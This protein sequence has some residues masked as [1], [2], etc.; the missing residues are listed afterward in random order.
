MKSMYEVGLSV[1]SRISP[2]SNTDMS[3]DGAGRSQVRHDADL[4]SP[5]L[6]QALFD[7]SNGKPLTRDDLRRWPAGYT[8]VGQHARAGRN[9]LF[10]N[11]EKTMVR[12]FTVHETSHAFNRAFGDARPGSRVLDFS[13]GG[14]EMCWHSDL[15]NATERRT[16]ILGRMHLHLPA[17]GFAELEHLVVP[18]SDFEIT[19]RLSGWFNLLSGSLPE[20]VPWDSVLS[21]RMRRGKP[22]RIRYLST[23]PSAP[24]GIRA[25]SR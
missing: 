18:D 5:G 19:F 25:S 10:P 23:S 1:L 2:W 22:I 9:V 15:L 16:A 11:D 17:G 21:G 7:R 8:V 4:L 24:S 12:R 20:V 3:S 14:L 6:R 13:M